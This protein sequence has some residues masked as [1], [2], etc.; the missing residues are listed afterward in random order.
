M[1]TS[2]NSIG[3]S[4]RTGGGDAVGVNAKGQRP[5]AKGQRPKAKGQRPKAKGKLQKP[6]AQ[7]QKANYK[8]LTANEHRDRQHAQA[9]TDKHPGGGGGGDGFPR[10]TR[11]RAGERQAGKR[12]RQ[13]DA[14]G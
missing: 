11:Q 1:P 14:R 10:R 3:S 2:L 5:K 9:L 7:R 8:L 4:S 12:G 13:Q 6:K